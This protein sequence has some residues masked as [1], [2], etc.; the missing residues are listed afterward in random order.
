MDFLYFRL[1]L[2]S[3]QGPPPP[4]PNQHISSNNGAIPTKRFKHGDEVHSQLNQSQRIPNQ[5]QQQQTPPPPFL[6]SQQQLQ[7]LQY[8]QKNLDNLNPQQQNAYQ[9]LSNQ[10]RMMLQYQQQLRLQRSQ[11]QQQMQ[12]SMMQQPAQNATAM[13]QPQH[14]NFQRVMHPGNPAQATGFMDNNGDF[15]ARQNSTAGILYENNDVNFNSQQNYTQITSTTTSQSD[16]GE[17]LQTSE[18]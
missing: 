8:L 7:M 10:H 16:L 2:Q 3:S 17:Y 18:N 15:G 6:M 9:Q 5:P 13:Q 4:Y 14:S 11:Q 1:I 12:Q